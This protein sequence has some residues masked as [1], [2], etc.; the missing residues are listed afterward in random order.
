[1][2]TSACQSH[3]RESPHIAWSCAYCLF[4][5]R[6]SAPLL[7][8]DLQRFELLQFV[9]EKAQSDAGLF[10]DAA[11]SEEIH[12]SQLVFVIAEIGGLEQ[13]F[14]DQGLQAEIDLAQADPKLLG[15]LAL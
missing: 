14:L 8:F 4:L 3:H 5:R 12:V 13:A 10:L 11:G 7:D 1:M 9:L 6:F 2:A 15:Q